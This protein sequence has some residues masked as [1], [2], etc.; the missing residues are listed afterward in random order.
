[1][2]KELINWK[3]GADPEL[4]LVNKNGSFYSAYNAYG[5]EIKGDKAK[6]EPTDYGGLQVDGM[7]VEFNIHPAETCQEFDE[8]IQAAL[9]DI[10]KRFPDKRITHKSYYEFSPSWLKKQ[11]EEAVLLGCDPDYSAWVDHGGKLK[12]NP[13]PEETTVIR[14]AGGHVHVGWTEGMEPFDPQHT[15][16]AAEA[17]RQLDASLI[18]WSNLNDTYHTQRFQSPYGGYGR[19]RPKPYGV[20]YRTLSNFWIFNSALRKELYRRVVLSL[21]AL[22]DNNNLANSIGIHGTPSSLDNLVVEKLM[23]Y[24]EVRDVA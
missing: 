3:I 2:S 24:S 20:E 12:A 13:R 19:M 11:P 22:V 16:L 21:D 15:T 6:P 18:P 1:M 7:A 10:K 4:F 5:K 23:K 8:R 9:D 14:T 17:C